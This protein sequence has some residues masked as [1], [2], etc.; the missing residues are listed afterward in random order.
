MFWGDFVHAAPQAN[1]PFL[2]EFSQWRAQHQQ[3]D[4]T[5]VLGNHDR[6]MQRL[7]SAWNLNL[8]DEMALHDIVLIHEPEHASGKQPFIAGHIHPC[9][10]MKLG[11]SRLRLSVFWLQQ[12]SNVNGLI[13]PSFGGFTGGFNIAPMRRDQC[14]GVQDNMLA[15]VYG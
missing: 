4:I 13:L 12:R 6:S 11:R 5:L 7:P 2:V 10:R 8:L 3:L 14:W 15:K 1:D 9:Y